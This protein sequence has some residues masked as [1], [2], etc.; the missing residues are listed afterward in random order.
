[1]V[2]SLRYRTMASAAALV[3][4]R[5]AQKRRRE[6]P[7]RLAE[8]EH[9]NKSIGPFRRQRMREEKV[10]KTAVQGLTSTRDLKARARSIQGRMAQRMVHFPAWAPWYQK[11]KSQMLKFPFATHDDF[12][13]FLSLVGR[14]LDAEFPAEREPEEEKVIRVGS[15][16][17][18]KAES[19]RRARRD[20][21]LKGALGG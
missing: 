7:P 21:R 10:F 20:K 11:A 4:V 18:V 13:S 14:G 19:A 3:G 9:I 5:T 15:F 12:I 6:P 2:L 8:D 1:M 17:R 16:A